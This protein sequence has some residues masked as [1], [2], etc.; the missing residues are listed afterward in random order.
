MKM[1]ASLSAAAFALM[2]SSAIASMSLVVN[3]ASPLADFTDTVQSV[4]YVCYAQINGPERCDDKNR[5]VEVA[6]T[7]A[8]I[9]FT[10]RDEAF[11]LS[12]MNAIGKDVSVTLWGGNTPHVAGVFVK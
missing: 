7:T 2:S 11:G 8:S 1:L 12:L 6:L 9:R 5:S 10:G 3:P 4:R